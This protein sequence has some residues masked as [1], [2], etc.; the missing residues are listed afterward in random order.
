MYH[1]VNAIAVRI[2]VQTTCLG[3]IKYVIVCVRR[4][5]ADTRLEYTGADTTS[6]CTNPGEGTQR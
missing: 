5:R 6:H 4:I 2:I 1:G 3:I